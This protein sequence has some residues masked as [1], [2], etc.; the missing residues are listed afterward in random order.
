MIGHWERRLQFKDAQIICTKVSFLVIWKPWHSRGKMFFFFLEGFSTIKGQCKLTGLQNRKEGG[1]GSFL[2]DAVFFLI[3]LCVGVGWGQG[4]GC[5]LGFS[6]IYELSWVRFSLAHL[7]LAHSIVWLLGRR[8]LTFNLIISKQRRRTCRVSGFT[9]AG[10]Y[11]ISLSF[12]Y[13]SLVLAFIFVF[14]STFC[15]VLVFPDFRRQG[16]F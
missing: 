13:S 6:N 9:C 15:F 1:E 10:L 12:V 4:A 2:Y 16:E 11:H 14:L 8:S 5:D 3:F 7:T